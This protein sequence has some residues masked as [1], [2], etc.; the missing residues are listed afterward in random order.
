VRE[1]GDHAVVFEA[2]R[3]VQAFVLKEELAGRQADE[4]ADTGCVL[5]DGLAFADGD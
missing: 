1:R 2:A 3:R 4:F 5:Q